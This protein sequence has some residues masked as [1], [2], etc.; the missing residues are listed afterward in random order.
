MRGCTGI[1]SEYSSYSSDR[2]SG[3]LFF[4]SGPKDHSGFDPYSLN[5]F[6]TFDLGKVETASRRNKSAGMDF[7]SP[8]G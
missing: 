2:A 3:V 7:Y 6:N 5:T 1:W 8:G 4:Y